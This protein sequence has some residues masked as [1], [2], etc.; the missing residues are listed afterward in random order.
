MAN[1]AF[2]LT[3]GMTNIRMFVSNITN[4]RLGVEP[5]SPSVWPEARRFAPVHWALK[6]ASSLKRNVEPINS[7]E[8][9]APRN[10]SCTPQYNSST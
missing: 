2:I 9:Q 4:E 5:T 1:A 10:F 8:R 7:G 3:N 6:Y